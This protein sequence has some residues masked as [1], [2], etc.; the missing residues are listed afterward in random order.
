MNHKVPGDGEGLALG[1]V[2]R[3]TTG[4]DPSNWKAIFP[5]P[6]AWSQEAFTLT[7][8]SENGSVERIP[9]QTEFLDG[10][11]VRLTG[12]PAAGYQFGG[13][14]GDVPSGNRSVNPLNLLMDG[15][16]SVTAHFEILHPLASS[17][18]LLY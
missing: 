7:V 2:E 3:E 1:R 18:W 16:K 10:E 8:A 12:L 17:I 5:T 13:W 4:R 11:T 15:D 14:T 9:N 6:G